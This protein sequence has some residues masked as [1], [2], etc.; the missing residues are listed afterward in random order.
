MKTNIK[1]ALLYSC[2]AICTP[3]IFLFYLYYH[4][5]VMN[6]FR[7]EHAILLAAI[8]SI[9][10]VGILFAFGAIIRSLE[11][12]LLIML[13]FWLA[14][15]FFEGLAIFL[16]RPVLMSVILVI[17]ALLALA[18][19][20][21]KPPFYKM[22]PVFYTLAVMTA[23]L[24]IYNAIPTLRFEIWM[25]RIEAARPEWQVRRDFTVD[26]SL[27]SPD[28]YWFHMDGMLNF[29]TVE[30]FFGDSQEDLRTALAERGFV[31]NYGAILDSGWTYVALPAMF[32]PEFYDSYFGAL[33]E[34][35]RHLTMRQER[36]AAIYETLA[37]HGISLPDDIV[38]Y[39]EMFYAFY[40]AGYTTIMSSVPH[41]MAFSPSSVHRFYRHG[42]TDTP[43]AINETFG[44]RE[45][46]LHGADDLAK[47]LVMTTPLSLI[48]EAIMSAIMDPDVEWIPMYTHDAKI[49]TL[50][51]D[52]KNLPDERSILKAII[53]TFYIEEPILLFSR[54]HFAHVY[55]WELFTPGA[56][57]DPFYQDSY[58]NAHRYEAMFLLNAIDLVL[59]RNP[60]AVIV[61]QSDHG[62]HAEESQQ[63]LAADFSDYEL[64]ELINSTISAVRI[65]PI[66]GGLDSYLDPRDI[67]RV[68]VNRFVGENYQLRFAHF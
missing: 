50:T 41:P 24:F 20:Y 36:A 5:A 32:S 53:D 48:S 45:H 26:A 4:N 67:A 7:F 61:I 2:A 28:I 54:F 58:I 60:D 15:W 35:T 37:R 25:A 16:P 68:L 49:D 52:T 34:E 18:F 21:F 39:F 19:R 11:A 66:Y 59:E 1:S 8:F 44:A 23:A 31:N 62:F 64:H 42:D 40:A 57:F 56:T 30:R 10:S 6:H 9:I 27:P 51:R 63:I 3:N 43:L 47:L 46:F 65:P 55:R 22:Q 33:L 13:L 29:D 17:L 38:P 12:S 14:F